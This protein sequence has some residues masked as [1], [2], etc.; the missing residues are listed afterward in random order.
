MRFATQS[1]QSNTEFHRV[2]F[3]ILCGPLWLSVNSVLKKNESKQEIK[4][5]FDQRNKKIIHKNMH[6]H[7]KNHD[8]DSTTDC[9]S[10]YS[11]LF[12]NGLFF[13]FN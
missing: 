10:I 13:H 2:L 3:V 8:D 6:S 9:D 1:S 5:F 7:K 4:A 11:L 12:I